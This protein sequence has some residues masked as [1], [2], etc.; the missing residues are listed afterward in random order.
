MLL[1]LGLR[2][3][4]TGGRRVLPR[5]DGESYAPRLQLDRGS[6]FLP[7]VR[8]RALSFRGI[9]RGNGGVGIHPGPVLRC[10]VLTRHLRHLRPDGPRRDT[11]LVYAA[12]VARYGVGDGPVDARDRHSTLVSGVHVHQIAHV[13]R[14]RTALHARARPSVVGRFIAH[15]E[16]RRGRRL[17]VNR[18]HSGI[19]GPTMDE[20]RL[21]RPN[22]GRRMRNALVR[23]ARLAYMNEG[24]LAN[25]PR[26]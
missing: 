11:R 26:R 14:R 2:L 25:K 10:R 9:P 23:K 18:L 12:R 22:T 3:A 19:D 20:R 7:V 5:R 1:G 6:I 8:R 13:H 21:P 4:L 24:L 15:G 16:K 17:M